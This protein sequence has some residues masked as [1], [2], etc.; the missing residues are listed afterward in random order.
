MHKH[1]KRLLAF[2]VLPALALAPLGCSPDDSQPRLYNHTVL[3]PEGLIAP[4]PPALYHL[5]TSANDTVAITKGAIE[6]MSFLGPTILKDADGNHRGVNFSVF[7][8][9]CSQFAHIMP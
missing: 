9:R 4:L 7:S 8:N 5:G 6:E 3:P 1:S 2:A